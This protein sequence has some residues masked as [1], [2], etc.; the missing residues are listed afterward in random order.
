VQLK[1]FSIRDTKAEIFNPPFFK[2]THGEAERDFSTLVND[3][4]SMPSKYP[5]DY[6]LY[7]VGTYDDQT[8][9]LSPV[10]TPEHLIK[11][12]QVKKLH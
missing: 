3:E 8:G 5:E 9:K 2:H 6:D 11:A 4:K 7:Y 1:M 10:D 12:I